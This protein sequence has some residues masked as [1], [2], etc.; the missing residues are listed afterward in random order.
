[1]R[2]TCLAGLFVAGLCL[3][4]A[5][6]GD[7]SGVSPRNKPSDYP[8][9]EDAKTAEIAAVVISSD[10]V[11]RVF[12]PAVDKAYTVVEVAIY[13]A[14]GHSFDVDLSSFSLKVGGQIVH[15]EKPDDVMIPWG[16]QSGS[17]P[18]TIGN[19]GPGLTEET[20]VI[21]ARGTNPV[22]G[23]PQTSTGTYEDVGVSNAPRRVDQPMPSSKPDQTALYNRIAARALAQGGTRKAIAGYLYFP[24]YGKRRK[25]DPVELDW[26][27]DDVSVAL[28]FPK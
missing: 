13:P 4:T 3:T 22:T 26:S 14:D 19:R 8:A 1:M 7:D 2:T 12:S 21:V 10:Q 18:P 15:A 16:N 28:K 5:L 20:G 25:N 9:H 17:A 23:R 11:K 6:A 27:K 24:Q